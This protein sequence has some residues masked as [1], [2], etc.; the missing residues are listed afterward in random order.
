MIAVTGNDGFTGA[1]AALLAGDV[2]RLAPE[3]TPCL[4]LGHLMY[5]PADVD[6]WEPVHEV[7]LLCGECPVRAACFAAEHREVLRSDGT[8]DVDLV[9]GWRAGMTA[10][11]RWELHQEFV[12]P[13]D[14]RC[15][16]VATV[17]ERLNGRSKRQVAELL[18]I[19]E[20]T[21]QRHTT[22]VRDWISRLRADGLDDLT[23]ARTVGVSVRDLDDPLL[24]SARWVAAA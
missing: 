10:A 1:V 15:E 7:Q 19:S 23:V 12:T 18:G 3:D 13:A 21:V 4:D 9:D 20:R 14:V 22:H 6:D 2:R 24:D 17:L 16:E 5:G 8:I 11:T